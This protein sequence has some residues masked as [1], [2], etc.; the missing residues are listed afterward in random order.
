[1]KGSAHNSRRQAVNLLPAGVFYKAAEKKSAWR[2][3]A[4]RR[5]AADILK[6]GRNRRTVFCSG[7][8]AARLFYMLPTRRQLSAAEKGG[9]ERHERLCVQFNAADCKSV[10][11]GRFL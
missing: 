3:V 2:T 4:V 5:K 11:G 6:Y 1:M 9:F 8:F 10:A 7:D